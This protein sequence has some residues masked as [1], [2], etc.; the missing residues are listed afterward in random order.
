MSLPTTGKF[1]AKAGHFTLSFD[2]RTWTGSGEGFE[3]LF[4]PLLSTVTPRYQGNHLTV[5]EVAT[6][7]LDNVFGESWTQTACLID[8]WHDALKPGEID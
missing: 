8:H 2:G 1:D 6:R 7:V 5:R 4:L 3:E